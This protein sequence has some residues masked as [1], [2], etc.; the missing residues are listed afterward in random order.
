MVQVELLVLQLLKDM[1]EVHLLEVEVQVVGEGV[2][3][4]VAGC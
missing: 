4:A 1:G 2:A 3:V